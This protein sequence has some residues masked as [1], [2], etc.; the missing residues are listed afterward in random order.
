MIGNTARGNDAFMIRPRPLSS[1]RAPAIIELLTNV[2]TNT[3]HTRWAMI[4]LRAAPVPVG[5]T[6]VR[7]QEVDRREEQRVEDDPELA[8]RGVVVLGL[9]VGA[10]Q[11][12]HEPAPGPQARRSTGAAAAIPVAV[13]S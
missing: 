1:D 13:D 4:R 9:Q 5:R 12:P 10:R 3:A 6:T 2:N 11:V 7:K 8:D